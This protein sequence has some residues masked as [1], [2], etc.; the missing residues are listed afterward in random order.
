[1]KEDDNDVNQRPRWFHWLVNTG[2]VLVVTLPTGLDWEVIPFA[3][4]AGIILTPL[5]RR[6]ERRAGRQA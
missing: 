5:T 1:M 2:F 4:A 6:W 3:V